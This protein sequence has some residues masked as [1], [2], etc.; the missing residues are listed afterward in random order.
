MTEYEKKPQSPPAAFTPFFW[1]K[2][3]IA[4][5]LASEWTELKLITDHG[6][7]GDISKN[8]CLLQADVAPAS[9]GQS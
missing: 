7:L 1:K 5:A 9:Y 6:H 4:W 2:D 3:P 8:C